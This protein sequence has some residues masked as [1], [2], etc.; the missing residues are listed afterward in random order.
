[1][2]RARLGEGAAI[3]KVNPLRQRRS[4]A[5]LLVG[6]RKQLDP[7]LGETDETY[8]RRWQCGSGHMM[9]ELGI[10]DQVQGNRRS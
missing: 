10:T 2:A 5:Y 9:H 6:E 3:Y 1:M 4:T 7:G 8:R